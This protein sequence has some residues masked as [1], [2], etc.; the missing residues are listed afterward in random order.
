MLNMI[1]ATK[2]TVPSPRRNLVARDGLMEKLNAG[3]SLGNKLTLISASAG[4]GKTVL[5]SQWIKRIKQPAAWLSLDMEDNDFYYFWR[6]LIAALQT[7]D[8]HI[9]LT[10]QAAL[11]SARQVS[12]KALVTA[13]INDISGFGAPLMMV[14]DDYHRLHSESIHQSIN[15]LID[16]LP[17][18][19][20]LVI[21]TR[22]EPPLAIARF[23]AGMNLTEIHGADLHF[24]IGE[25][26]RLMNDLLHCNLSQ[27]D[28]TILQER[29]EGWVAGLQMAALSLQNQSQMAKHEFINEFAGNDKF[30]VDYLVEDV[31]QKQPPHILS[32]LLK[33]SV[34]D[35][36]CAPLC[37]DIMGRTDSR[38]TLEQ[39]ETANLFTIPLDNRRVWFRYHHL[40]ADLLRQRLVQ[41]VTQTE[42]IRIYLT[43]CK[44]HERE[45]YISEAVSYAMAAKDYEYTADLIER[46]VLSTFYRSETRL[47]YHWLKTLP[48][49]YVRTRPLLA[50]VYASCIML[51]HSNHIHSPGIKN[52][53]EEWLQI[54]VK[55]ITKPVETDPI[56]QNIQNQAGHYIDKVR[57]YLA[58]LLGEDSTVVIDLTRKALER[59]P[60][61][62]Q[63]FRSALLHNLG[64]AYL[65]SGNTGAAIEAFDLAQRFGEMS[66]D[67][68]N[69]SSSV[70][71]LA[72]L[73]NQS[74]DLFKTVEICRDGLR[75]ISRLSEGQPIPYAGI[76]YIT[77]GGVLG[78]WCQF[79]EA[80]DMLS[81]GI[82]LLDL[83]MA[84][85]N[86]QF[87]YIEMAYIKQAMGETG[88]ALSCLAR[89]KQSFANSSEV[90][91]A[92]MAR[93]SLLA[94]E[95]DHRYFYDAL[96]WM[97]TRTRN[98]ASQF[99]L[100]G[101]SSDVIQ[102]T[103]ARIILAQLESGPSPNWDGMPFQ[104]KYLDRQF[105]ST[106]NWSMF[107]Y[108]LE[109]LLLQSQAYQLQGNMDRAMASLEKALQ[110]GETGGYLRI[111]IDEGAPML[112]L[113]HSAAS[114]KISPRFVT[115]LLDVF[116]GLKKDGFT[117]PNR[118]NMESPSLREPL[119]SREFEVL[120]LMAEGATNTEISQKLFIAISTVKTHITHIFDKLEVLNR[121]QAI[122]RARELK[123]VD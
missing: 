67:L 109:V 110:L 113:L 24:S 45:G 59:L 123:L 20:H 62:E 17:S 120:R 56:H 74:G 6:N 64:T 58:G 21:A 96:R 35:K 70:N 87:G 86:Q 68:F 15:F 14:L 49:E 79:T 117:A 112:K 34:L 85:S 105:E 8:T 66:G 51:T 78:E 60:E 22:E 26:N 92:H 81:T 116:A 75:V 52:Q 69:L 65:Y 91:D 36:F 101:E 122:V 54:A 7:I 12:K 5:I 114:Q 71:Y 23:R 31:L 3:L 77:L 11:Q 73:T 43:A 118:Q 50:A 90:I 44:W 103:W 48:V 10:A 119:S 99:E 32:F 30:I 107:K 115:K 57:A 88:E 29:T 121:T 93:I 47:V 39:L 104:P 13:V 108:Q 61:N 89:A 2:I 1:L 55:N 63:M 33:T 38:G 27:E 41:S 83:T 98:H 94:A 4:A 72:L 18:Q 25:T 76:L 28:I 9:G 37:D 84:D 42:I 82:K 95:K 106:Q 111:F 16:N 80:L 100:T 40:F 53:I 46:N 19:T 97:H 102:L